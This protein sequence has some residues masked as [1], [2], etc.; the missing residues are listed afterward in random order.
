[1]FNT[2][3]EVIKQLA[4]MHMQRCEPQ[5]IYKSPCY[6]IISFFLLNS[7]VFNVELVSL[8]IC[9]RLSVFPNNTVRRWPKMLKI[10]ML[11]Y[12]LRN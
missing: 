4:C 12:F 5:Y 10:G 9:C 2:N 8:S 1:M 3:D 7:F 6:Y 11:Y